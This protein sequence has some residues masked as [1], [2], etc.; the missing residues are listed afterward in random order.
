MTKEQL[1]ECAVLMREYKQIERILA[2]LERHADDQE[3][4]HAREVRNTYH[5]KKNALAASLEAV[6]AALDALDPVERQLIRHRF[7]DGLSVTQTASKMYYSRQQIFRIQARALKK[8]NP[9]G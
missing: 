2:V 6:E 1:Q 4:E 9:G 7:I 3:S 8:M 5:A